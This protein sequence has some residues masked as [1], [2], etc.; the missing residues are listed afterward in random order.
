M[1]HK[2]GNWVTAYKILAT[3]TVTAYYIRSHCF[4]DCVEQLKQGLTLREEHQLKVFETMVLRKVFEP[5]KEEI[6]AC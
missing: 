1:F 2:L 6:T 5:K 4:M 3:K